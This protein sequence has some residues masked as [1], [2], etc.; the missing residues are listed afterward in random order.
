MRSR[1]EIVNAAECAKWA[2]ELAYNDSGPA[3]EVRE[4]SGYDAATANAYAEGF[5]DALR[6]ALASIGANETKGIQ[7]VLAHMPLVEDADVREAV[8]GRREP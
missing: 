1:Q 3:A 4:A 6:Y 8:T 7:W 5:E 2:Q